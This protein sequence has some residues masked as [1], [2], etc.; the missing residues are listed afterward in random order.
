MPKISVIVPIYKVEAFIE[1]CATSLMEQSLEDVEFIFV[2][3]AS[4]DC[5]MEILGGVLA[6]FPS[7]KVILLHH[8]E[9]K[10]LPAARNTGM[11]AATG[12]YICH[13]DSDD[14]LE[15]DML[16]KMYRT[17]QKERADYVYC[18]FYLDFGNKRRVLEN[19]AFSDPQRLLCEGFLAGRVK[20]NVWNKLVKR[21]LYELSAVR[22]PEG[23]SMAED[24]T[25]I[26]VLLH[27]RKT[28]HVARPLYHYMKTN[29]G[30]FTST[31]SQ[32]QLEDIRFNVDRVCDG[33]AASGIPDL[34]M[35]LGLFKLNVKL[36]FL[37]SGS[38][39]QYR[40]WH[41][42]YPEANRFVGAN[43]YLPFRTIL[44]QRM[45]R[46]HLFPLVWLY[47]FAVNYLYYGLV[48]RFR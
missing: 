17:A 21:E 45:A 35:N 9:N 36:P 48:I 19:P 10:G 46:A 7:R 40:L 8:P 1:G 32:R 2:D 15:P 26:L 29:A 20:F 24:M 5:S 4:P 30:A 23:H 38:Y 44:V 39:R 22:F 13:V 34:E 3:D 27:A 12:E 41:C 33:V 43:K 11:A 25:M 42:W 14:W 16:E 31:F 6:G 18:D 28:A 37:L 47:S